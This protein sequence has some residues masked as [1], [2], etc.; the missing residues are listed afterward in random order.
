M[1]ATEPPSMEHF[2]ET[3]QSPGQTVANTVTGVTGG[4]GP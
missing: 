2:A 1:A 3:V 4:G